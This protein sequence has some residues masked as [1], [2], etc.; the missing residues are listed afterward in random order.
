MAIIELPVPRF[1]GEFSFWL[2]TVP[3][4]A[5]D[6]GTGE[7]DDDVAATLGM[8]VVVEFACVVAG[9]GNA[10]RSNG[11]PSQCYGSARVVYAHGREA[12]CRGRRLCPW[13]WREP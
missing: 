6:S 7:S 4:R 12:E 5:G 3:E 9:V 10:P 8:A 1:W 2:E 11:W 13:A